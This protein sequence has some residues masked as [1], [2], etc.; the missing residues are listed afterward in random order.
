[1]KIMQASGFAEEV[2]HP[3]TVFFETPLGH[4]LGY[5]E[6]RHEQLWIMNQEPGTT[7]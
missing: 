1:M 3:E 2:F 7:I 6:K 5:D 4:P